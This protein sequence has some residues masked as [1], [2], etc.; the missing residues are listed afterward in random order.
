MFYTFD[1]MASGLTRLAEI[2][3]AASNAL[4]IGTLF[5]DIGALRVEILILN[6]TTSKPEL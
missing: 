3:S 4:N 1:Y 6:A 2:L 5:D